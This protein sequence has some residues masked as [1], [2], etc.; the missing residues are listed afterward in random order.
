MFII[1]LVPRNILVGVGTIAVTSCL[2]VEAALV[3]EFKVGPDQNN[4]A[5]RA[6]AAMTFCY[7][8]GSEHSE[9]PR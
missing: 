2:V 7:V 3:A 8:V 9:E 6:A 1:D 4:A 5:L